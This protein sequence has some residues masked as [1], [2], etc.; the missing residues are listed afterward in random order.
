[1][2]NELI[3]WDKLSYE[4]EQ[5][6]DIDTIQ[7]LLDKVKTFQAYAKQS[8]QS[9]ETQNKIAEYRLRLERAKGNWLNENAPQ[10]NPT[11]SNQYEK[12]GG[13]VDDVNLSKLGINKNDSANSRRIAELPE[14]IFNEVI[15]E[16][17]A[18]NKELTTSAILRAAREFERSNKVHN[19][20]DLPTGIYNIIYA[21]PPWKYDFAETDNR[22]I[23][24]QYPTMTIDELCEMQLPEIAKNALLVMWATAPK[25]LEA[26]KVINSWGFDYKTHAVWDKEKIGMGYWFRGQHEILMLATKGKFSPPIPEHRFS[27]IFKEGRKEHSCKP[28]FYY[29]WI[30]TA[31]QGNK[32]E[33]FA[34]TKREGWT[35]WGNE[36]F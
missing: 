12:K 21:D 16:A 1:M 13:K 17:K 8:K 36:Q 26:F 24:N 11:G 22:K 4:I 2:E 18:S 6:K 5:A 9:L 15:T 10:G 30:E 7:S 34:R 35:A 20:Q 14:E 27:S 3:K 33:L 32:I 19:R 23:E 31:F 28:E 25:L 29:E